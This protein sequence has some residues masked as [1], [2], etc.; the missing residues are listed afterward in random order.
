MIRRLILSDVLFFPSRAAGHVYIP[1][2]LYFCLFGEAVRASVW[3]EVPL[4]PGHVV[5]SQPYC[6]LVD[7]LQHLVIKLW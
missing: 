7:G 2:L 6:T 5:V 4:C 3:L 1:E